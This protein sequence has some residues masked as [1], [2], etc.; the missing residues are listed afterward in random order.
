MQ[1]HEIHAAVTEM[2]KPHEDKWRQQIRDDYAKHAEHQHA[3]FTKYWSTVEPKEQIPSSYDRHVYGGRSSPPPST[4][5]THPYNVPGAYALHPQHGDRVHAAK[6]GTV[7]INHK[8]VTEDADMDFETTKAN[9]ITRAT[10]KLSHIAGAKP[11]SRISGALR[12]SGALQG[13]I[14]GHIDEHNHFTLDASMIDNYRYGE[15]S[16]NGSLTHYTQYPFRVTTAHVDGNHVPSPSADDLSVRWGGVPAA[17][18]ERQRVALAK[19]V[20]AEWSRKKT[21]LERHVDHW[22]EVHNLVKGHAERTENAAAARDPSHPKHKKLQRDL[23]YRYENTFRMNPHLRDDPRFNVKPALADEHPEPK[24]LPS[25]PVPKPERRYASYQQGYIHTAAHELGLTAWP[26]PAEA[27]E[28]VAQLRSAL[29]TH[30]AAK[31]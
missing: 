11:V 3:Q 13:H 18:R 19:G 29:A 7:A 9:F 21:E 10:E 15:N 6:N 2:L 25:L 8:K 27:K 30:K 22:K 1:Q 28:K 31:P 17:T 16:A 4:F 24:P 12:M 23:D 26:T 5:L 20:K 14:T